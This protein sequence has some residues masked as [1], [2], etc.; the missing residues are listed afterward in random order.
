[1]KR[2]ATNIVTEGKVGQGQDIGVSAQ[3][4][5]NVVGVSWSLF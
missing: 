1:M 5:I 3:P 4:K 2:M